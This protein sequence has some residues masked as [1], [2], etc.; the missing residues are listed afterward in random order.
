MAQRASRP[1]LRARL[2]ALCGAVEV[3]DSSGGLYD[4]AIRDKLN[5]DEGREFGDRRSSGEFGVLD[6]S[7][8][9]NGVRVLDLWERL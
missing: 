4:G 8:V 7:V 9:P 6:F 1:L 5:T 3:R 2:L